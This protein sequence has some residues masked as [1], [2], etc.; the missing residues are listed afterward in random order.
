MPKL[1]VL[2]TGI[3]IFAQPPGGAPKERTLL[4]DA[5]EGGGHG[6]P[7][8]CA[9]LR[10]DMNDYDEAN[11]DRRPDLQLGKIKDPLLGETEW[12]VVFL[13]AEEVKFIGGFDEKQL[14]H[15]KGNAEPQKPD[16]ANEHWW[17]WVAD[18]NDF[19]G[20]PVSILEKYLGRDPDE[21]AAYVDIDVGFL[22][23]R[24]L[25]HKTKVWEFKPELGK[26]TV[27]ALAQVVQK[28][29]TYDPRAGLAVHFR[30]FRSEYDPNQ[31]GL[32][33]KS[34]GRVS[35]VIGNL[36]EDGLH[37]KPKKPHSPDH[38]FLLYYKYLNIHLDEYPIPYLIDDDGGHGSDEREERQAE[39]RYGPRDIGGDNCPP[40]D[41]GP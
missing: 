30:H 13:N 12:G 33:F 4:V 21:I 6:I 8:H 7:P 11:S 20:Q 32:R 27:Q 24:F 26:K 14:E 28:E 23:P 15:E 2:F 16:E 36:T 35:V 1:Q 40:I 41:P 31:R 17:H 5:R 39:H 29:L 19:C 37:M 3:E 38:H 10:F 18:P 9:F 25:L 22:R 34:G